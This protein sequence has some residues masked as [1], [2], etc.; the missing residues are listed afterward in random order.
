MHTYLIVTQGYI[1]LQIYTY[2]IGIQNTRLLSE[3]GMKM[4]GE[5]KVL[6]GGAVIEVWQKKPS[7]NKAEEYGHKYNTYRFLI[8]YTGNMTNTMRRT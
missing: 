3:R 2:K 1:H 6:R 5:S 4:K 7:R 8:G